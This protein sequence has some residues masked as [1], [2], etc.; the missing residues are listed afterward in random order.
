MAA[1]DACVGLSCLVVLCVLGRGLDGLRGP[2]HA[3]D[4]LV[5]LKL[6]EPNFQRVTALPLSLDL[7]LSKD[8]STPLHL[9][10]ICLRAASGMIGPLPHTSCKD[11]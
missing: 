8:A 2:W 4:G 1:P 10:T 11:S 9:V 6:L 3:V 5:P 7:P